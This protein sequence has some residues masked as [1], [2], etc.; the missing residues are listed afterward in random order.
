MLDD[1][2]QGKSLQVLWEKEVDAR[3][4]AEGSWRRDGKR[5]F[6]P[7]GAVRRLSERDSME[8][9]YLDQSPPVPIAVAPEST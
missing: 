2:A 1:D 7:P 8:L 3:I 4:L 9:R 5:G 6:D